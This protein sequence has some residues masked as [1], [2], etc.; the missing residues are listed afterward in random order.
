[1]FRRARIRRRFRRRYRWVKG[2]P[3]RLETGLPS[4]LQAFGIVVGLGL[5]YWLGCE[6]GVRWLR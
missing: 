6:L 4:P 1:M 3:V 5:L 2:Q